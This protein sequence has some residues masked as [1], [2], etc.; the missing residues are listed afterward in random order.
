MRGASC[1]IAVSLFGYEQMLDAHMNILDVQSVWDSIFEV[2]VFI[3]D[4]WPHYKSV[5]NPL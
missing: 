2:T 5:K 3:H 1:P 4:F